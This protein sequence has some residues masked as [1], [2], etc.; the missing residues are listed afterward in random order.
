MRFRQLE[1]ICVLFVAVLAFTMSEPATAKVSPCTDT[2]QYE[3]D[4]RWITGDSTCTYAQLRAWHTI[5]TDIEEEDQ[6]WLFGDINANA[7]L[8][9]LYLAYLDLI[10]EGYTPNDAEL[11][12]AETAF[13][14]A[15][16]AAGIARLV[17]HV[18]IPFRLDDVFPGYWNDIDGVMFMG[19]RH[20]AFDWIEGRLY[21][22]MPF[23][24]P[25]DRVVR[26]LGGGDNDKESL[27]VDNGYRVTG[28]V[29]TDYTSFGLWA[30][31]SYWG[32]WQ[33]KVS[34]RKKATESVESEYGDSIVYSYVDAT[35]TLFIAG[36]RNPQKPGIGTGTW[37]GLAVGKHRLVPDVRVGRSEITVDFDTSEIDVT[38]SGLFFGGTSSAS[39]DG[40]QRQDYESGQTL[41][42]KGLSLQEDGSFQDPRQYGVIS[43][44]DDVF[45]SEVPTSGVNYKD[46]AHS[47]RGQFYGAN[48][49]EVSGVFNK[50]DIRGS[51]GAYRNGGG[52]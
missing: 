25:S 2:L 12:S 39:I 10:Y 40:G 28:E 42:W 14:D 13:R 9:R 1:V 26:L 34:N 15:A 8:K 35:D 27:F 32:F 41:S 33:S 30:Q 16:G 44:L 24:N 48:G 20:A 19:N 36:G 50:E 7:D 49:N 22:G 6:Q 4:G 11:N 52:N 17:D 23:C 21:C 5:H 45:A 47:L 43:S 31:D 37:Q 29:D 51:F 18:I 38:I 3:D 46:T